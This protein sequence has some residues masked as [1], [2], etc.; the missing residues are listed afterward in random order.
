[1]KESQAKLP[2]EIKPKNI[3]LVPTFFWFLFSEL[4]EYPLETTSQVQ[5]SMGFLKPW[6]SN[7]VYTASEA[8]KKADPM[9]ET[10]QCPVVSS[11]QLVPK[12]KDFQYIVK[13]IQRFFPFSLS[14]N[15]GNKI[16]QVPPGGCDN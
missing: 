15:N 9:W 2:I 14:L 13:W 1:M 4:T 8:E 5:T 3:N 10:G 11:A 16:T 7:G 12:Y 6:H